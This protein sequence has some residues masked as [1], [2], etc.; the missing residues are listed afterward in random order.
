MATPT[1]NGQPATSNSRFLA[2]LASAAPNGSYLWVNH[3][4]GNPQFDSPW[5]GSPYRPDGT[6]EHEVDGWHL[7]NTYFSVAAFRPGPEGQARRRLD[8]F[9]RL[10]VLVVDDA[11]PDSLLGSPSYILQTSPGKRQIGFLL[12]GADPD[13]ANLQLVNRLVTRM[14]KRGLIGGDLSGNNSIRYVRLPVG[15]N[16]K[17]RSSGHWTHVLDLWAPSVRYTLED[18]ASCLGLDL[19]EIRHEAAEQP[20]ASVSVG[21]VSGPQDEKLRQ[22]TNNIVRGVALHESSI[23][24]AASLVGSG[25]PGGAVVNMLRGLFEASMAPRD[26]RW[27]DRYNDIPRSVATAEAKFKPGVMPVLAP[28]VITNPALQP[29]HAANGALQAAPAAA[30]AVQDTT[31]FAPSAKPRLLTSAAAVMAAMRPPQWLVDGYL[32]TDALAMLYGPPNGGKSFVAIDLACS[33]ATGTP[34]LGTKVKRGAVIYVAGEGHNGLARRLKAW[35]VL[36]QVEIGDVPLY[37]SQQSVQL[38]NQQ[39]AI[40]LSEE[41]AAIAI[42]RQVQPLLVVIDTL[43]RNFGGD[44][45]SAEDATQFVSHIDAFVRKR[46]GCNVLIIHHSGHNADR[47]RGS[48]AFKAA[49]DQELKL[50]GG[51]GNAI[52]LAV[53][54]MKDGDTPPTRLFEIESVAVGVDEHGEPFFAGALQ[55]SGDPYAAIIGR[56]VGGRPVPTSELLRYLGSL[57]TTGGGIADITIALGMSQSAANRALVDAHQMG[58]ITHDAGGAFVVAEHV[59]DKASV[60][61]WFLTSTQPGST[62]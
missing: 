48:T 44:E 34:W 40:E 36:R 61:G 13:C 14:A 24:I 41:I 16:Q 47:A 18:A 39:A 35:Q 46:F 11:E 7:Y 53:T 4:I 52:E 38:F 26:N 17:A 12:D 29:M 2:E 27:Q 31:P 10:L 59:K 49:M 57:E 25:M 54:R 56:G 45:N 19:D 23:E 21:M 3:F 20:G 22:L 51:G 6:I 62:P 1:A 55:L 5:G 15:Q 42:E 37:L 9:V 28:V 60:L 8:N 43:A 58:L 50:S 30:P 32:E 33:V